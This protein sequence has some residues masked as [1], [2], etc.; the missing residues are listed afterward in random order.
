MGYDGP[1]GTQLLSQGV[2]REQKGQGEQE[3][4]AQDGRGRCGAAGGRGGEPLENDRVPEE[5]A[6]PHPGP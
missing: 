2:N 3:G 6:C 4:E 1:E 5:E